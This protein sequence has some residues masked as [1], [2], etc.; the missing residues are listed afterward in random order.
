MAGNRLSIA[1]LAG[2][3]SGDNLGGPLVR[4]LKQRH[5][6]ARIVGIGGERMIKEGLE[7]WFDLEELSVNGII[8]PL[9]RLPRLIHILR[10]TYRRVIEADVDVFVGVDFNFF[11]LLL[12]RLLKRRGIR[13]VH[14][15]S[16]TVWA[17]RK[18]RIRGIAKSVDLMMTLYPFETAIFD[19]HGIE[20]RFVGHPKANEIDPDEDGRAGAR[21]VLGYAP[22]ARVLAV[23]PGSRS[24]EVNLSGPDFLDASARLRRDHPDLHIAVAAA[25]E[26]RAAQIRTL[27]ERRLPAG[28]WSITTG[29]ALDVMRAA[30]VVLVN[31]G[32]A[33]LEA[34]LL[35]RPMVM[36]YRMGWLT[37]AIVSR[38]VTTP[39]FALPNILAQEEL[40]P[41]LIQDAATPEAL[42]RE[43]SAL[44]AAGPM[45]E[46][47]ARFDDIHRSLRCNGAERAAEAVLELCGSA[48]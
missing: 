10:E 1:L 14:Y 11:N 32:T 8:D 4:A 38:M 25:N 27:C 36:S 19:A 33:T 3:A 48:D 31:S 28:A 12:E 30:D 23:L 45:P 46:L 5:P 35:K 43:L 17:W 13:T 7:S 2:E 15:V 22:S 39:W 34:M 16:P 9:L 26:R 40:V 42:A 20:A 6:D 41:E 44:L 29:N 37:Y 47:M 18:G 21:E 24:S